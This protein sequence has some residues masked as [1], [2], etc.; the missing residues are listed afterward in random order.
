MGNDSTI[1]GLAIA[2]NKTNEILSKHAINKNTQA[3]KA[4]QEI[5][6]LLKEEM[7]RQQ[8]NKKA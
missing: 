7:T 4:I 6:E 1:N 8:T 2:M 5:V 3:V